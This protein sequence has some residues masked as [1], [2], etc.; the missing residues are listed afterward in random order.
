MTGEIVNLRRAR[1]A[2]ERLKD[3]TQAQANRTRFG[4]SKAERQLAD[5]TNALAE[6]RLENHR[7]DS[8]APGESEDAP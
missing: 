7:R 2:R 1:K 5:K 3:E 8:A 4:L 6:R